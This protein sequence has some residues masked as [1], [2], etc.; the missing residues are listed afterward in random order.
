MITFVRKVLTSTYRD[1]LVKCECSKF[2]DELTQSV[3]CYTHHMNIAENF[4]QI[5]VP[6]SHDT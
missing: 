5:T 6:N 2:K 4:F 3:T 1:T